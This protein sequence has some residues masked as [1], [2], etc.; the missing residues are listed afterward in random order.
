M[1]RLEK[2]KG[3]LFDLDGTLLQ[4]EMKNFIPAYI[5][6]LAQHF[7]DVAHR[8]AFANTVRD[9]ITV[10][11][12]N[13]DPSVTNEE[14][15]AEVLHYRFGIDA[16]AVSDRLADFYADGLADLAPLVHPLPLAR[17]I[18]ERNNFV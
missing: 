15:F 12:M 18:L 6:G 3:V 1:E 9:A 14:Q 5:D 13:E 7:T 16:E 10:L 17:Q 8:Y 2:I 11:L 4:V